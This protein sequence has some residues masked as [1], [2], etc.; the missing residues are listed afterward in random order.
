MSNA[1]CE[2]NGGQIVV[3]GD[4]SMNNV[5][6]LSDLITWI[7]HFN[8]FIAYGLDVSATNNP[9]FLNMDVNLDGEVNVQDLVEI[10]NLILGY[11]GEWD[12]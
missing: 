6:D 1:Q 3:P 8:Q 10:I 9:M 7:S 11:D 2:L 4:V 12:E 5:I